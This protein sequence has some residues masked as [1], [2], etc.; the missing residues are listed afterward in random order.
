MLHDF[1]NAL[2]SSVIEG[3][4]QR[5]LPLSF[6]GLGQRPL[7]VSWKVRSWGASALLLFLCWGCSCL[8]SVPFQH[9]FLATPA[10]QTPTSHLSPGVT[11]VIGSPAKSASAARETATD[12]R[13]A[14]SAGRPPPPSPLLTHCREAG[15]WEQHGACPQ[16]RSPESPVFT[17]HVTSNALCPPGHEALS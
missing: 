1:P 11:A 5:Q 14:L 7:S 13:G 6:M 3:P 8:P 17:V 16:H 10:V 9:P 4:P 15:L 2:V 12:L